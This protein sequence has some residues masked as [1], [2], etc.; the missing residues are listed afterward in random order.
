MQKVD[1]VSGQLHIQ[2]TSTLGHSA[3][4][5]SWM[6]PPTYLDV[7]QKRRKNVKLD[8]K[9]IPRSSKLQPNYHND[10]KYCMYR[11]HMLTVTLLKYF[12]F[13]HSA[14]WANTFGF[15][16]KSAGRTSVYRHRTNT[17][18]VCIYDPRQHS[19]RSGIAYQGTYLLAAI[20]TSAPSLLLTPQ[21]CT[22]A[23]HDPV[24]C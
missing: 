10:H 20:A 4:L 2:P 3:L 18:S 7:M 17:V 24:P 15:T 6:G 23:S 22:D 9:P 1:T 13:A 12:I 11:K 14:L 21:D 5:P 16:K 19:T 8:R